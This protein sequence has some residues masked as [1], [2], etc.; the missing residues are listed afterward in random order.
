MFRQ[1]DNILTPS[2]RRPIRFTISGLLD[3]S[4]S[5]N[6]AEL[7][8]NKVPVQRV[9]HLYISVI[10]ND[11]TPFSSPDLLHMM[12][13]VSACESTSFLSVDVTSFS[14]AL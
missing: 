7:P 11:H 3:P 13:I 6:T 14:V 8:A 1:I 9:D 10:S 4:L 12:T 2:S 5:L